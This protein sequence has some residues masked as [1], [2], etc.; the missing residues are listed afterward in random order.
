M[1]RFCIWCCAVL[2]KLVYFVYINWLTSIENY[3]SQ[4]LD[5]RFVMAQKLTNSFFTYCHINAINF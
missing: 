3:F 1:K 2:E 4:F 5:H